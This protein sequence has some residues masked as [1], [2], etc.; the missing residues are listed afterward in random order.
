[1]ISAIVLAAGQSTR[2][3]AQKLLLPWGN[4]TVIGTV[5]STVSGAGITDIHVVTGGAYSTL[6]EHLK[7]YELHLLFNDQ[8]KNGE[9]VTS[10]KVGLN[11]LGEGTRAILVVLG[12]QPQVEVK[13]ITAVVDRFTTT[14]HEIVVPS[15]QM[16]R[17]HPWLCGVS[18]RQE[19]LDLLPPLTLKD[20]LNRHARD[21]DYV[22]V[23]TP[24]IIQDLDTQEDYDLYKP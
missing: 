19:I 8:Y 20:F 11:N 21:I 16:H 23:D 1:M 22:E 12:D 3:G 6:K 13:V 15:Y 9:M 5:L 18:Y 14:G 17:G 24:G 7:E 4:S 2:M 10:I